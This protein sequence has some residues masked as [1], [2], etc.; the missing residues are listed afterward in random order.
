VLVQLRKRNLKL[1][2]VLQKMDNDCM[3]IF[4]EPHNQLID[5]VF[6]GK[7]RDTPKG[8]LH[9]RGV[10]H[11]NSSIHLPKAPSHLPTAPSH[12]PPAPSH[13]PPAPSITQKLH[14]SPNSSI[15]HPKAPSISQQL[16]PSPNCSKKIELLYI[17]TRCTWSSSCYVL[18]QN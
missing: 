3:S 2:S 13:L 14:Q 10:T 16:H 5:S 9:I 6:G 8:E 4:M 1:T 15:N 18:C 7:C 11:L 17:I 12:L